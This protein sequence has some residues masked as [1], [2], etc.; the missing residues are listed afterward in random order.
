MIF[1]R[2]ASIGFAISF[3]LAIAVF[4]DLF[5]GIISR[6]NAKYGII[7]FGGI[8]LLMN[9]LSFKYDQN[10]ENNNI[11]FW[12]GSVIVFVG[13]IF[14]IQHYNYDQILLIIG[15]FTVALSYFYNPF[16]NQEKNENILDN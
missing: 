14:K 7:V 6:T 4:T 9:L 10:S 8:A 5:S 3:I 12:I 15:I 13:L 2:L 11:V 1:K 16:K